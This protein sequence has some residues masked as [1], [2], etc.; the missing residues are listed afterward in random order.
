LLDASL[1]LSHPLPCSTMTV[2]LAVIIVMRSE[3]SS[4]P[5]RST[6]SPQVSRNVLESFFIGDLPRIERVDNSEAYR[7]PPETGLLIPSVPARNA[8]DDDRC[9]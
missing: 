5:R 3:C 2:Y 1:Q 9:I 6:P 4:V 8:R 7:I